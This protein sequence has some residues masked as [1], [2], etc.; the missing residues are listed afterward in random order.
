[1]EG[2]F[3]RGTCFADLAERWQDRG[4][5]DR[6]GHEG[7]RYRCYAAFA[8]RRGDARACQAIPAT[9]EEHG[10]LRDRCLADV[11]KSGDDD[12]L[13]GAI[14]GEGTRDGCYMAIARSTGNTTLCEKISDGGLRRICSGDS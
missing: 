13:C 4:L 7:V 8:E 11:A 9:S 3:E 6:A 10:A 12:D 14:S 2:L 1:V 5:C